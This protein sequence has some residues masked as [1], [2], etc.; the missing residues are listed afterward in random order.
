MFFWLTLGFQSSI[1]LISRCWGLNLL[2]RFW[3]LSRTKGPKENRDHN[4]RELTMVHVDR[5]GPFWERH[6]PRV[7]ILHGWSGLVVS[8]V[9][10]H[11]HGL[12]LA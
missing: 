6:S 1:G 9:L 2:S 7:E 5:L 12:W 8:R 4:Q 3:D 10:T 11:T